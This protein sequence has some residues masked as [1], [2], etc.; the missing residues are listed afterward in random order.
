MG[1]EEKWAKGY[2]DSG[3]ISCHTCCTYVFPWCGQVYFLRTGPLPLHWKLPNAPYTKCI[4]W[5]WWWPKGLWSRKSSWFT[6][7]VSEGGTCKGQ[8]LH[9]KP[10]CWFPS[11]DCP[12]LVS[13]VE[14]NLWSVF[15]RLRALFWVRRQLKPVLTPRTSSKEVQAGLWGKRW[16][17]SCLI[18]KY[19]YLL[20]DG[21]WVLLWMATSLDA[22][23]EALT[24]MQ[25]YS[26]PSEGT[27]SSIT[28]TPSVTWIWPKVA[29][30]QPQTHQ[31]HV[32]LCTED[33]FEILFWDWL[34]TTVRP[35]C[36]LIQCSSG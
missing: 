15:L 26:P 9:L 23:P 19:F 30:W 10:G 3:L 24:A 17:V 13:T 1:K 22:F 25:E 28:N 12:H 21:S 20:K 8:M 29:S 18:W 14:Q 16:N 27:I 2:N 11:T 36:L 5:D 31:T 32:S 4:A 7:V 6:D 34:P 35:L 33:W